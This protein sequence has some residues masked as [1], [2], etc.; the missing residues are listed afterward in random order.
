MRKGK[1]VMVGGEEEEGKDGA[2]AKWLSH[3]Y[4]Y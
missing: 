2:S 4:S 3:N 1:G